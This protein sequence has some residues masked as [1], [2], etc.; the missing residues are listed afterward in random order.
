[1]FP[2]LCE[3]PFGL[4][5]VRAGKELSANARK[6][7]TSG[8]TLFAICQM[9][10]LDKWSAD[11][12]SGGHPCLFPG[13]MSVVP[14]FLPLRNGSV[15]AVL[16]LA[17]SPTMCIRPGR[18]VTPAGAVRGRWRLLRSGSAPS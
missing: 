1:M 10:N 5:F 11:V 18:R 9:W 7:E 4:E 3:I 13:Q 6:R 12:R 17:Q 14:G 8:D 2:M 16:G 15:F